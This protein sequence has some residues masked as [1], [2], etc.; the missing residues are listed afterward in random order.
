MGATDGLLTNDWRDAVSIAGLILSIAGFGFAAWQL[1]RIATST[2]AAQ[3]ATQET[4]LALLNSFQVA[5][6]SF[7]NRLVPEIDTLVRTAQLATLDLRLND[8]REILVRV[9]ASTPGTEL[10]AELTR[11]VVVIGNLQSEVQLAIAGSI[12]FDTLSARETIRRTSD[13]I[14]SQIV[15][16]TRGD[17]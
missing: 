12:T 8:L 14:S 11:V 10:S 13:S 16:I 6:L 3:R 4:R 5:E 17:L 9:R 7:A 2:R 15:R 1:T